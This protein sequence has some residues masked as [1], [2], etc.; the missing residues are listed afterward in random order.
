[1]Q[2]LA[3][4]EFTY[5]Q[6]P[7]ES[8]GL[9]KITDIKGNTLVW[10]QLLRNGNFE[11]TS[12]WA[13]SGRG[14]LTVSN[15]IAT[16]TPLRSGLIVTGPVIK[17]TSGHKY[18]LSVEVKA[19]S[20]SVW[21]GTQYNDVHARLYSNGTNQW[22]RMT[23]IVSNFANDSTTA[24]VFGDGRT[25]GWTASQIRNFMFIDLTAMGLDITDPSDFTSLFNLPYYAYNQGSLLSFN[26]N[27][28]KTVGFNQ[29]DEEWLVGAYN[30]ANGSAVSVSDRIR[31]KNPIRIFPSIDYFASKGIQLYYYDANMNYL[32][33]NNF[34]RPSIFTPPSN[35]CYMNF[36]GLANSGTTYNNDIC[37][38][39]SDPKRNGQYEPYKENIIEIP[40]DEFPDGMDGINDVRDYKNETGYVKRISIVDLGSLTWNRSVIN[41]GYAFISNIIAN[42]IP[43]GNDSTANVLCPSYTLYM[44]GNGYYMPNDKTYRVGGSYFG[45]QRVIIR[46][47]SYTDAT[48]FKTAMAGVPLLFEL[49]TPLENYGIVDLGS[50]AW[51]YQSGYTRFNANQALSGLAKLPSTNNEVANIICAKYVTTSSNNTATA[52]YDLSVGLSTNGNIQI[53]DANFTDATAF[54]ESLQDVYLLY[55]KENPQG[56]VYPPQSKEGYPFFKSY[57]GG[58]EQLLPEN[59]SVPVTAPILAD[60][61]YSSGAIEV[62]TYPNPEQGGETSG[63]G[64]YLVGEEATVNATPNEH[65]AFNN[66][67]LDGEIVSTDPEYT[68]EVKDE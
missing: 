50:L 27:G 14:T 22:Q 52:S 58:T 19:D 15:N 16:I 60:M 61:N 65:Y 64:W 46:D 43:T 62:T 8:D 68:F 37:I 39:I 40:L 25:S 2:I 44:S 48:A 34:S 26:G 24:S 54:K 28:M 41:D 10:N 31:N 51:T 1:M 29:W 5:R 7:T 59:G 45:R 38:N 42:M 66:W 67:V 6:S 49:E 9:A 20:T 30:S 35:A 63:D 36:N 32:G 13:T 23:I 4:Q 47:D 18:L 33:W 3:D 12:G 55:E 56:L 57:K 11:T 53:R 17:I 21:V